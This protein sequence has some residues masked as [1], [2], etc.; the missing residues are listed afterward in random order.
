ME[1]RNTMILTIFWS[2]AHIFCFIIQASVG[3][4]FMDRTNIL[5]ERRKFLLFEFKGR[6]FKKFIADIRLSN[7]RAK[8]LNDFCLSN[9]K[10]FFQVKGQR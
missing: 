2:F 9:S 8:H 5:A 4:F 10:F 6:F 1:L 7:V 3:I